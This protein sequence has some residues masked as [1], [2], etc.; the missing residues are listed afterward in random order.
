VVHND[1]TG[2]NEL[3]KANGTR[4]T[5]AEL[6]TGTQRLIEYYYTQTWDGKLPETF[7]GNEDIANIIIGK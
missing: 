4:V 1:S 2:I 3:Y 5:E 7:V 6:M